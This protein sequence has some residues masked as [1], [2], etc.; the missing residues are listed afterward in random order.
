[1]KWEWHL[2]R[3]RESKRRI[4][5][6]KPGYRQQDNF[7]VDVRVIGSD[8]LVFAEYDNDPSGSIEGGEFLD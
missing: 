7:T 6:G 1:M 5:Q 3:V 8:N 2:L 4:L